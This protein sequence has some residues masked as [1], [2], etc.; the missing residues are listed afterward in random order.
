[1]K[2]YKLND[3]KT[4]LNKINNE[5]EN[6][7]KNADENELYDNF[8][9]KLIE[10]AENYGFSE[11]KKLKYYLIFKKEN[12]LLIAWHNDH[13]ASWSVQDEGFD[14]ETDLIDHFNN[15]LISIDEMIELFESLNSINLLTEKQQNAIRNIFEYCKLDE[16]EQTWGNKP[17]SA[18]DY[19]NVYHNIWNDKKLQQKIIVRDFIEFLQFF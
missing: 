4:V 1:M 5:F 15:G 14:I 10:I 8:D 12:E 3:D 13:S 18:E 16:K 7:K 17:Y 6:W 11:L 9:E 19:Q 2:W